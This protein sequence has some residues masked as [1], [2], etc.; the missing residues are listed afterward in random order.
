MGAGSH[1]IP[2][3]RST[4]IPSRR[5]MERSLG[6]PASK[7]RPRG[8]T[9]S[10]LPNGEPEAMPAKRTRGVDGGETPIDGPSEDRAR[11]GSFGAHDTL[12]R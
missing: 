12:Q 4:D 7:K 8:A 2:N 9:P 6:F 10:E 3:E 11:H 1:H 5:G